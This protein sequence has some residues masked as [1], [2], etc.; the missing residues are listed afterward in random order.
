MRGVNALSVTRQELL[1]Q[2][3]HLPEALHP[4]VAGVPVLVLQVIRQPRQREQQTQAAV[5]LLGG[6]D[7]LKIAQHL[8][9]LLNGVVHAVVRTGGDDVRLRLDAQQLDILVSQDRVRELPHVEV[10]ERLQRLDELQHV[11]PLSVEDQLTQEEHV[12]AVLAVYHPGL[13]LQRELRDV[14][15][16][17][18][19]ELQGQSHHVLLAQRQ[20]RRRHHV[21]NTQP[22]QITEQIS[23]LLPA[24]VRSTCFARRLAIYEI[25]HLRNFAH[26][27][28]E[29][30]PT[31]TG[32]WDR[33]PRRVPRN[34]SASISNYK[35]WVE[36]GRYC[37]INV[38][39]A[40]I[41]RLTQHVTAEIHPREYIA[42]TNR[43]AYYNNW[44]RCI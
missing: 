7:L 24:P 32:A 39:N 29:L 19:E 25:L 22:A 42:A 38:I 8:D 13:A 17:A 33:G 5:L 31:G 34:Y 20:M 37:L 44:I 21:P 26:R 4:G 40:T 28:T 16:A 41:T 30:L 36:S 27:P 14:K 9:D 15:V 10:R 35:L 12:V 2:G 3:M 1:H 18:M 6:C 11:V 43:H 23:E